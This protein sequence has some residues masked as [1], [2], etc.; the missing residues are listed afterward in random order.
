LVVI[1]LVPISCYSI[2]DYYSMATCG[3][4]RLN[5]HEL[6]MDNC[7]TILFMAIGGYFRLNYHELLIDIRGL[8]YLWLLVAILG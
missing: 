8:Y 4:F 2:S 6:L 5:Y 7:G 1:I 3:Y